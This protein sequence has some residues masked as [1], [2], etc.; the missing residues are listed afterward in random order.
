MSGMQTCTL[1]LF[2]LQALLA[3]E[4]AQRL[5]LRDYM[6]CPLCVVLYYCTQ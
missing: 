1:K 5:V 6:C 2:H 3:R 4:V